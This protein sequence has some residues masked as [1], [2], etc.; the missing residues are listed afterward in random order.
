VRLQV[1][2]KPARQAGLEYAT[3]G[4]RA[5]YRGSY[6]RRPLGWNLPPSAGSFQVSSAEILGQVDEAICSSGATP[7]ACVWY[8]NWYVATSIL[9][10]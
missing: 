7:A 5:G 8:V 1:R 6:S 4:R 3:A 2:A 9:S 10:G